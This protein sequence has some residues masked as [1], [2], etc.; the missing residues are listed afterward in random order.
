MRPVTEPVADPTLSRRDALRAGALV[1]AL[2]ALSGCSVAARQ[3]I[4][5]AL[6]DDLAAPVAL[7]PERARL[8]RLMNRAG[9]GPRPGELDR[10]AEMGYEDY[11]E[12]QLHPQDVDDAPGDLVTHHLSLYQLD[13][14]QLINWDYKDVSREL[15]AA[16]LARAL[17]SRRHLYESVVGFWSD[18]FSIYLGKDKHM[19]FLKLVD[20]RDAIR[21]HA[22]GSF[23]DLLGA[24]ASSPAMLFYL[25]NQE[26]FAGAPNENYARE[27]MELHTLG[28]D[29]GYTQADVQE[30]ARALT[31]WT[32]GQKGRMQDRWTFDADVHDDGTKT[33]IGETLLAGQGAEDVPHLLDV[34]AAHP[35]TARFIATKL[36]RRYVA[37][38]PPTSLVDAVARTFAATQGDIRSLLRVI[39]LSDE[40]AGAPPRLKRPFTYVVSTVRAFG[41]QVTGTGYRSLID[42]LEQLGHVPFGWPMPDGYPVEQDAWIN[43]LLPRWNFSLALLSDEIDGVRLPLERLA[44]SAAVSDVPS[45]LSAASGLALA[46]PLDPTQQGILS[47]YVEAT[48]LNR[49]AARQRLRRALGLL[50]AGPLF[51]QS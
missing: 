30:M 1:S 32:F 41:G 18:H 6:P 15:I 17:Y 26:N 42:W 3:Q 24:S 14:G 12:Q 7:D 35:S 38:E 10:A 22:L 25:D 4:S 28:V 20:D 11:L 40:F 8:L 23:R 9:Y 50:L 46:R 34:L 49:P 27:L 51:Q 19:P 16:T 33:V 47:T 44:R 43:N 36:V 13:V 37:D 21:P 29:G 48:A 5:T 2:L 45:A 39:F 31:G